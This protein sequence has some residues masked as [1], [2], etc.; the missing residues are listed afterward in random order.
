MF[1]EMSKSDLE[2]EVILGDDTVVRAFG[3]GTVRFERESMQPMFL[4]DV[5]FVT[6]LKKNLVLVSMIEIEALMYMS[7][8]GKF[9]S[10]SKQ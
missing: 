7:L 6:G 1:T 4:K 2:M 9:T 8:M 5:L 10:F 3:R